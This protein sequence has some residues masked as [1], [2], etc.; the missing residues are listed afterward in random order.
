MEDTIRHNIAQMTSASKTYT[1][2][3][4]AIIIMSH[5]HIKQ[6]S[7]PLWWSLRITRKTYDTKT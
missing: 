4:L 1:P 3:L 5:D 2:C 7:T 6:A